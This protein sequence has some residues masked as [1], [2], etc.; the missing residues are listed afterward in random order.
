M[1]SYDMAIGK[2]EDSDN[3]IDFSVAVKNGKEEYQSNTWQDNVEKYSINLKMSADTETQ[4]VK[5]GDKINYTI[6]IDNQSD[7]R[8]AGLI[9]KDSVPTQ[10]TI[11]RVTLDGEEVAEIEGNDIEISCDVA[12]KSIATIVIETVVNYSEGRLDAEPITNEATVEVFGETIATTSEINHI[13]LANDGSNVTGEESNN[14]VDNNDIAKGFKTITGTAWFDENANGK[15]EDGESKLSGIKVTLLNTQTNNLVKDK[16]GKVLEAVT[17]E[18]G[19]YVLNNIGNGRYIVIFDYDQTKYALT[20]YQVEGVS[21]SENSNAM[22]NELLIENENKQVASTDI[23]EVSNDNISDI[24]VGLIKLENFDLQLEKFVSKILIQNS[25][26]TTVKEYNNATMAKAEL[27]GK[28]VNGTT[29]AVEYKIRVTNKGEVDGYVK[30]IADYMPSDLKF[31]SELNK[32]WY[33]SGDVLYNSSLANEKIAT[34]E[35]REITLTL[36]KAMTEDNVGRFNN[37]AEITESYNELGLEDSNSTPGNRAQGENDMG[38]ADVIL[39]IKTG[40]AIYIS[41][42]IVLAIALGIVA[43][44]VIKKQNKIGK[45]GG[46]LNVKDKKGNS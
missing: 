23:I 36:T 5:A 13:I 15:K 44:V 1:L 38:A 17:N 9:L 28:T 10:L 40:G 18:N 35:T 34:G 14:S 20:K 43:F 3:Q 29:V 30:K 19:V 39:S 26:G 46:K 25:S 41:I 33:Q 4:Y 27:D 12:E 37:T 32:D 8:T 42:I 21:Q 22:K 16:E 45:K 11:Q 2:T 6:T 24:N 7:S 31:S